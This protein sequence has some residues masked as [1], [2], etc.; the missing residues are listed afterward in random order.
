VK[1]EFAAKGKTQAAKKNWSEI[2]NQGYEQSESRLAFAS[3]LGA[4]EL[5]GSIFAPVL[6]TPVVAASAGS[7]AMPSHPTGLVYEVP[8]KLI[9]EFGSTTKVVDR[10]GISL[11]RDMSRLSAVRERAR[12][13]CSSVAID[14]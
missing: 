14:R 7:G 11:S 13:V 9:R 8:V 5:A 1:Q 4:C 6:P 2:R 3:S 12:K 10:S